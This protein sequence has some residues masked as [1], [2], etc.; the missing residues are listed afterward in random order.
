MLF[1]TKII[2]GKR[3]KRLMV[4]VYWTSCFAN[5]RTCTERRLEM[6]TS[7]EH[8]TGKSWCFWDQ[9]V[10]SHDKVDLKMPRAW[11]LMN[12]RIGL[13]CLTILPKRVHSSVFYHLHILYF[14]R[15]RWFG[16]RLGI[17]KF[18]LRNPVLHYSHFLSKQITVLP[19]NVGVL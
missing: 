8:L 18:L 13:K 12:D 5:Y 15:T 2:V 3:F 1:T 6:R 17:F 19:E 7:P 14:V 9:P 16:P 4:F 11:F 10:S